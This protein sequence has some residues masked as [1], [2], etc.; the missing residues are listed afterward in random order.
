MDRGNIVHTTVGVALV[1]RLAEAGDRIFTLQRAREIAPSVGL[2]PG[3]LYQALHYLAGAGWVVRLR[4]GLYAL[5]SATP[6]VAP[7][8]EFEIAMAL[9]SP[10]AISYWSALHYHGL[11]DQPPRHVFVLTTVGVAIPR[12]RGKKKDARTQGY[13][14]GATVYRFIQVKPE[15]FFGTE[16]VWIGEA[17]V[18]V[19]D[20]ERTLLD[21]LMM[22]QYCGDFAEVLNAFAVRGQQLDVDRIV[23]YALKMDAATAKRLGWILERQGVPPD[24]LVALARVSVRGFRKLDPTGMRRGPCNRRWMIQENLLGRM[25]S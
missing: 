24:R 17:R 14:V 6:G 20:P 2:S 11:T 13:P 23:A 16:R 1:R 18:T 21:G 5:A 8:H 25:Q 10:A 4:K 15:R 22:P 9:V 19:T 7:V 3:Y 12:V